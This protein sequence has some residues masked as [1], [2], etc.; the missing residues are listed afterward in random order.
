[1]RT[2]FNQTRIDLICLVLTATF[3]IAVSSFT[4]K[5]APSDLELKV[6]PQTGD[7]NR[8]PV[9]YVPMNCSDQSRVDGSY[10]C[11]HLAKL[12]NQISQDNKYL[13]IF[14]APKRDDYKNE[15]TVLF[16]MVGESDD[17][18][19]RASRDRGIVSH[20]I[21]DG[22]IYIETTRDTYSIDVLYIEDNIQEFERCFLASLFVYM[23]VTPLAQ[24]FNYDA[25]RLSGILKASFN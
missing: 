5:S 17:L 10:H 25:E 7:V 9:M 24:F 16:T 18:R 2:R 8:N 12:S 22:C 14:R 19:E 23:N 15:L 6:G 4:A 21:T 11:T 3:A 13:K 1:M 20:E